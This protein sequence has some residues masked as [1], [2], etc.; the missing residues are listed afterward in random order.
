MQ[1]WHRRNDSWMVQDLQYQLNGTVVKERRAQNAV[2]CM[3]SQLDTVRA[4]V[5]SYR[6][7]LSNST[8]RM[9]TDVTDGFGGF[10]LSS[11]EKLE[12]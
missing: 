4:I 2:E 10:C 8:E 1:L 11:Y 9:R 5:D 6:Q 7:S 3:Q 12:S